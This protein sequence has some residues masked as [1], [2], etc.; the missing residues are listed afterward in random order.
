MD[1]HMHWNDSTRVWEYFSILIDDW[2]PADACPP[3]FSEQDVEDYFAQFGR[4]V[5]FTART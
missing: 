5:V 3:D 4:C 1:V 2:A